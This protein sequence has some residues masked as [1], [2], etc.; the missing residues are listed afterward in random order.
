MCFAQRTCSRNP[1]HTELCT[2]PVTSEVTTQPTCT[3]MGKTTYT[4][5]FDADWAETQVKVLTN[6]EALGHEW[7]KPTY[8]WSADG[9]TCTAIRV[10][11]HD[12]SHTE[13]CEGFVTCEQTKAPE[14]GVCG[15]LIY[16]AAFDADWAES[17]TLKVE[18]P[19]L[20]DVTTG[21]FTDVKPT[22]WYYEYVNFAV[23][24][25]LIN[26]ME[27][28]R[29]AP[30]LD[31]SRA[32]VVTVLWRLEGKPEGGENIF[33]D[34]PEDAWYTEAVSWAAGIG[35]V[36]GI[37][38]DKFAPDETVTREQLVAIL[39]R[40]AGQKGYPVS[41]RADLT[42]FADADSVSGYA[43]EAMQWAVAMKLID[44][45]DGMLMPQNGAARCQ[46]LAILM[47]FHYTF[48]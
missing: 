26:G 4:A 22:D 36:N 10:C 43:K 35:A 38:D 9:K 1:S 41:A 45:A 11:T 19:A 31:T 44:G 40:Y 16:T 5:A 13:T 3:E 12:S 23:Q 15:E 28:G 20:D 7:G 32:M 46:M 47:R 37:G 18:I 42:E 30:N 34:V 33:T 6:I 27:D 48:G 2:A 17:Q 8:Q 21:T 29:F 39:F 24:N 14:I 25:S